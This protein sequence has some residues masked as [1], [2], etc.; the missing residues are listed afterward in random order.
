[1]FYMC[2]QEL[3]RYFWSY[4]NNFKKE[5][6]KPGV[7]IRISVLIFLTIL[8]HF[9]FPFEINEKDLSKDYSQYINNTIFLEKPK[10]FFDT[11]ALDVESIDDLWKLIYVQSGSEICFDNVMVQYSSPSSNHPVISGSEESYSNNI[12]ISINN[13]DFFNVEKEEC[14][15][16][17]ND[18]NTIKIKW[19]VQDKYIMQPLNDEYILSQKLDDDRLIVKS[20][21]NNN[22]L[23]VLRNKDEFNPNEHILD[24]ENIY[25]TKIQLLY[26]VP[27]L[28]TIKPNLFTQIIRGVFF[29]FLIGGFCWAVI[30]TTVLFIRDGWKK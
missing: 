25:L 6:L 16:L 11:N 17:S 18:N 19:E 13:G 7:I 27:M 30:R 1:M 23:F 20:K 12:N 15:K 29:F 10:S 14:K 9:A 2:W 22:L 3:K 24:Y 8:L 28:I 4:L 26:S 5:Y 21:S